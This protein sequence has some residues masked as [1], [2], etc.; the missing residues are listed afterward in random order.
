M[1]HRLPIPLLNSKFIC[2][3]TNF[4]PNENSNWGKYH[5][6]HSYKNSYKKCKIDAKSIPDCDEDGTVVPPPVPLPLFFSHPGTNVRSLL[7]ITITK[8]DNPIKKK[9]KG[10]SQT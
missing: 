9:K 6:H 7:S 2:I 10:R 5:H 1:N 3:I 4:K 8:H